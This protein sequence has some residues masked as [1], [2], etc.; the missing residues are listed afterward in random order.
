MNRSVV[1]PENDVARTNLPFDPTESFFSSVARFAERSG[2]QHVARF[3]KFF[4]V[5]RDSA[6]GFF[7]Q[8]VAFGKQPADEPAFFASGFH[9][10]DGER[11]FSFFVPDF[12]QCLAKASFPS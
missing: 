6:P 12:K 3:D 7:F 10:Q 8:Q 9:F 2:A 11:R 1:V 5:D 4:E